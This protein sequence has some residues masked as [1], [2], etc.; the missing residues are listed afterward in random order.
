MFCTGC[1]KELKSGKKFCIYCGEPVSAELFEPQMESG[2]SFVEDKTEILWEEP[3]D[4]SEPF[5]TAI[6]RNTTAEL[7][8]AQ[9]E[10]DGTLYLG[11]DSEDP[12][13]Y[14][15]ATV[16]FSQ[17]L[18]NQ[19]VILKYKDHVIDESKVTGEIYKAQ[20]ERQTGLG[21]L[22]KVLIVVVIILLLVAVGLGAFYYIETTKNVKTISAPEIEIES[23]E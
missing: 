17:S 14:S 3:L 18:E 22:I 10:N 23:N 21:I 5:R 11:L 2:D 4:Q 13:E 8:N 1:G 15:E 16:R 19:R 9:K 6:S 7:S 20:G 12:K